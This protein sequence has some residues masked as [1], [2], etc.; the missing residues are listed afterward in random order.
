MQFIKV[1]TRKLL[2]PKDN[3]Y[4]IFTEHLPKLKEGDVVFITSKILAIHQGRCIKISNPPAGGL[5]SKLI[6]KEAD[7]ILPAHKI[8][9]HKFTLSIKDHTLIPNAGIDESNGNGYFILWPKNTQ[10]LLKEI[11]IFLKKKYKLKNLGVVST[12][13]HTTPLR[14]GTTGISTGFYGI[15]PLKDY[16]GKKDIFNQKLKVTQSNIVD[17]LSAMAVL[18]MGEGNEKTPIVILRQRG[19]VQFTNKDEF[20]NL[21]ISPNLDIYK[22]LLKHFRK[23]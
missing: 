12:D 17:T 5:K 20:K 18:L 7:Y 10:K 2:P 6:Q 13:S 9:G 14:W 16:R 1:K 3:I 8:S 15:K 23:V 22:P 21:V 19:L 11:W 4:K